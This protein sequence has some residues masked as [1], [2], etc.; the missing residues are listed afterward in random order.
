MSS[1]AVADSGA[2][3]SANTRAT[4]W[5]VTYRITSMSCVARSSATPCDP[6][7]L[8]NGLSRR[9]CTCR[10]RPIAPVVDAA[11]SA[12]SPPGCSAR[13]GR[14][15]ASGRAHRRRR[16]ARWR[17]SSVA[18]VGFSTSTCR[19]PASA[20]AAT[21]G[22]LLD[23]H[24]DAGE[25]ELLGGERVRQRLVRVHA[26]VHRG[27]ALA[28]DGIGTVRDRDES[29]AL[30][31]VESASVMRAHDAETDDHGAERRCRHVAHRGE[32]SGWSGPPT[33]QFGEA[34]D[35]RSVQT[36]DRLRPDPQLRK[37]GAST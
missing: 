34:I 11:A 22:R 17:R 21:T 30:H 3:A 19:P 26:G 31:R 37:I 20:S 2:A 12:P 18:A 1:C 25:V 15:R 5:P 28:A 14:R 7:R 27:V 32:S 35:E 4:S 24:G 13:C 9:A 16:S 10:T 29:R 8:G 23:G 33:P 36:D 6:W